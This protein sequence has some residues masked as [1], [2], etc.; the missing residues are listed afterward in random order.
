MQEAAKYVSWILAAFFMLLI[1]IWIGRKPEIRTYEQAKFYLEERVFFDHP[2]TLYCEAEYDE[3]KNLLQIPGGINKNSARAKRME[4]E[5]IV[6]AAYFGRHF[7]EWTTGHPYCESHGKKYAGRKCASQLS[8]DFQKIEADMY[9]LYPAIGAINAARG[10]KEY[11][12]LPNALPEFGEC[13]VKIKGNGF[14]PPDRAKGIVAR[15]ALY[16]AERY[17]QAQISGQKKLMFEDWSKRFPPDQ[18]ECE[19]ARRI[20]KLQGN[21]NPFIEKDCSQTRH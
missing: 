19:R 7:E 4:W 6:P 18:W 21:P 12:L 5:H 14:E 16:M 20:K 17:P 3:D 15:A 10:H 2:Y 1:L 11:M 9:N 13:G 8:R